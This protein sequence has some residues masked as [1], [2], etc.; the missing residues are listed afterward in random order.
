MPHISLY[1]PADCEL[2][3]KDAVVIGDSR[4]GV[5]DDCKVGEAEDATAIGTKI[6]WFHAAARAISGGPVYV[7]DQLGQVKVTSNANSR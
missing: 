7:S 6:S 3:G 4:D 2:Q 1:R 5:V